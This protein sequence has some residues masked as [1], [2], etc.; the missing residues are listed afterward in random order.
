MGGN[1][2]ILFKRVFQV[3]FSSIGIQQQQENWDG[4]PNFVVSADYD[5]K[6]TPVFDGHVHYR[7]KYQ[8]VDLVSLKH[9]V[10]EEK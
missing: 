10:L 2:L 5:M 7:G 9:S 4:R 8:H 3:P 6:P 1:G